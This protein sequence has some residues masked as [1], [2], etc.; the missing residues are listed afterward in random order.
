MNLAFISRQFQQ[1]SALMHRLNKT[2][3][4]EV[5]SIIM[6]CAN[7]FYRTFTLV[8]QIALTLYELRAIH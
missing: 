3:I 1:L 6:Q 2:C 5:L 7:E 4:A 8:L